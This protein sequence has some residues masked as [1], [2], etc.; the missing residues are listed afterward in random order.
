MNSDVLGALLLRAW[1]IL[2]LRKIRVSAVRTQ[3]L[4]FGTKAAT[5]E[6]DRGSPWGRSSRMDFGLIT[7]TGHR[8]ST[9]MA[10]IIEF[11]VPQNHKSQEHWVPPRLRGRVIDFQARS[12]LLNRMFQQR[13]QVVSTLSRTAG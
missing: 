3:T 1:Q 8:W 13:L 5:E 2:V 12:E 11:Y 9:A 6:Q 7:P 10:K 4:A